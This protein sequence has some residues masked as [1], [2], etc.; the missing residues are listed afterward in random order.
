MSYL[1]AFAPWIVYAVVPSA[2]WKWAALT[3]L[4]LTGATLV[5]GF[6]RHRPASSLIIELGSVVFFAATTA[7]AFAVP[8]SGL[9]AYMPAI[10]SLWLA[11]ISWFSLAIRQPFT[12]GIAKLS[13]PREVWD[14]PLFIRTNVII[15]LAWAVAFTLSGAVNITCAA[16]GAG[17]TIVVIVHIAS[18]VLPML[19]TVR[20][21]AVAQARAA[22]LQA[23]AA[24]R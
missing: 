5:A 21:V 9:R 4:V 18:F 14:K 7:F 23:A 24:E 3:A 15:T 12:L 22:R 17:T 16:A 6:A 2:Q 1:L 10:S 8:D 13:Q 11:L 19:F 20:Y